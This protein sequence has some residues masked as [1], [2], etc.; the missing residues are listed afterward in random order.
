MRSRYGKQ[1][2]AIHNGIAIADAGSAAFSNSPAGAGHL[3]LLSLGRLVPIK[4]FERLGAL[5]DALA[6]K[7]GFRP[8][9]TLAGEGPLE[10]ELHGVLRPKDP[11]RF[12]S[13]PGFVA[14]THSLLRSADALVITSDHEGIPM[15]ALE[16][17]ALGVPVFGFQ[18]GGLPEIAE[19][20][21]PFRLAPLGD[22]AALAQQIVT[23]FKQYPAGTRLLPPQD[24]TFDIRQ[25]ARAYERLYSGL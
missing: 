7:L 6:E 3:R 1:V 15:A 25:C 11:E 5:S 10:S 9:I 8:E 13:M 14:D 18:V 24:W 2:V 16:A 21:V 20:G 19:S 4:R 23:F 17:L 12:I 22:V